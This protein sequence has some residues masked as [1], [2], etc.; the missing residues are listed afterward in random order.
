METWDALRARR[1][2]GSSLSSRSLSRRSTEF[3]RPDDE[4]RR[5]GN[6]QPWDLVLV[7]DRAQLVELA[8]V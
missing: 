8:K 2:F 5:A 6:W 4:P 7:T 1:T 3:S